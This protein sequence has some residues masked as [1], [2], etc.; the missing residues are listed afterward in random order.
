MKSL[1]IVLTVDYEI[2]GNGQGEFVDFCFRPTNHML[3]I[4]NEYGA[5]VSLMAEMEHYF[6]MKSYPDVF[7]KEI[8][9]FEEQLARTIKEGHDVQLHLHPQWL[10]AKLLNN[11]WVF[12]Y[13][14][15]SIALLCDDY[16]LAYTRVKK[17][18]AWLSERL[19]GISTTYECVAFRAG[20][21]QMQP[22]LNITR[23]L[24][25]NKILCDTS[26]VQGL[27]RDGWNGKL[28]Y[29]SVPKQVGAYRALMN[30]VSI[31]DDSSSIMEMPLSVAEYNIASEKVLRLLGKANTVKSTISAI[32]RMKLDHSSNYHSNIPTPLKN[33]LLHKIGNSKRFRYLDFCLENPDYILAF[34]KRKLRKQEGDSPLIL[35]AHSKD[36]VFS[37]R[38]RYLLSK[39]SKIP[40]CNFLT[41]QEASRK[42]YEITKNV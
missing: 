17:A 26:V 2:H 10:G 22:S 1:D 5:K 7:L 13:N 9:M 35:I 27:F 6:A 25:S 20:F 39:I 3:S 29:R 30:N 28:D 38:F 21:F 32:Q 11:K 31:I 34:I 23:A 16:D 33:N 18:K 4:A 12:P 24:V 42:Y 40:Q 15:T 8:R 37:N 36:F 14:A 19:R 41:L